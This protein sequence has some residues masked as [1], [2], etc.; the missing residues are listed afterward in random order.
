MN[1]P[2][3]N[4]ADISEI[5]LKCP[6][7]GSDLAQLTMIDQLE[8]KYVND[9]KKR[10]ALEGEQVFLK[11]EYEKEI[12]KYRWRTNRLLILVFL[13]PLFMKYCKKDQGE[14]IYHQQ[15]INALNQNIE[16]LKKEN[17]A[18][19]KEIAD[20]KN[21]VES[22]NA[23][24]KRSVNYTVKKGD[25]LSELGLLFFNDMK[26]GYKIGNDN[27]I[28]SDYTETHLEPGTVLKI[29]FR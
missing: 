12:K 27:N 1:C 16:T 29:N 13:I 2:I 5:A 7:C 15:D 3:C 17:Q 19:K 8:E 11:K 9:V 4:H 23:T 6:E 10:V 18:S 24:V 26:A 21:L 20:L 28:W 22:S 14:L 25:R